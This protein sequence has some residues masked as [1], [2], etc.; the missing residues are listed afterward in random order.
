MGMLSWRSDDDE[1]EPVS[2]SPKASTTRTPNVYFQ[3]GGGKR[4]RDGTKE[5][6]LDEAQ[7]VLD[8]FEEKIRREN[9]SEIPV[10]KE[11]LSDFAHLKNTRRQTPNKSFTKIIGTY[12]EDVLNEVLSIGSPVGSGGGGTHDLD[13]RLR[14]LT[15]IFFRHRL[16]SLK[17]LTKITQEAMD[18]MFSGT[19]LI[20]YPELGDLGYNVGWGA[21]TRTLSNRI[22]SIGRE[23][24]EAEVGGEGGDDDMNGGGGG[25]DDELIPDKSNKGRGRGRGRPARS[26]T[27]T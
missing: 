16:S 20:V 24:A 27:S 5:E 18:A 11:I 25:E 19:E 3:S 26:H 7:D 21:F 13:K 17:R 23:E 4:K 15:N 9:L 10:F 1:T 14:A 2:K 22:K 12:T 8:R 6:C